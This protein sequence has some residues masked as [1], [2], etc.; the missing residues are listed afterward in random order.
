MT[1]PA[2]RLTKEQEMKKSKLMALTAVLFGGATIFQFG[3]CLNQFW[4]GFFNTGFPT[5]NRAINLAIDILN[6]ELFG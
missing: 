3:G 4:A 6:E 1:G 2:L 5:N